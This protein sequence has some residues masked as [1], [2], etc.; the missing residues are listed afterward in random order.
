MK[1][2]F[3]IALFFS[4]F[5]SYSQPALPIDPDTGMIIYK[6]VV[7]VDSINKSQLYKNALS[8]ITV[9]FKSAK[10]VIQFSDP[11]SGSIIAKGNFNAYMG[12]NHAGI[13]KFTFKIDTK[14]NKYKYEFSN[15]SHAGD[16]DYYP[17]Y[18][19]C[20]GMIKTKDKTFA[21]SHQKHYNKILTAMDKT[22]NDLI[23][24]LKTQMS[25]KD[26]SW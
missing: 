9:K 25:V 16:L 20:E 5:I 8:W 23:I 17:E 26:E 12:K 10:D 4:T 22:I 19:A 6:E 14:D 18:G 11:G 1:N 24:T 3:V 7:D 15:L 2:L 21:I 13:I